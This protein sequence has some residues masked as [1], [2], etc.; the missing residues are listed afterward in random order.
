MQKRQ[1]LLRN[2]TRRIKTNDGNALLWGIFLTVGLILL[3]LPFFEK[4]RLHILV[5]EA[6]KKVTTTL[7]SLAG[8]HLYDSYSP[9]RDGTSG[10]FVFD[11]ASFTEIKDTDG[12]FNLFIQLHKQ[13]VREGNSLRRLQSGDRP[14]YEIS[15]IKIFVHNADVGER[16]STYRI[17]YTLQIPQEL[18]WKNSIVTLNNQVQTVRYMN[19]Y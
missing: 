11:G 12:F 10:A 9:V 16:H 4:W 5:D 6:S 15:D 3:F 19:K 1:A 2:I 8:S 18:L 14:I 7:T 17:T 13:S